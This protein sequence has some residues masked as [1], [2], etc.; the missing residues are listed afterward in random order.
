MKALT[1]VEI[2]ID[3]CELRYG[4][5]PCSAVLGEDSEQ[6]C[7]NTAATCPVRQDYA[8]RTLT[9]RYGMDTGFNPPE[10]H[11]LAALKSVQ[12]TPS[13]VRPGVDLGERATLQ[14][15]FR[16]FRTTDALL[17]PYVTERDYDPYEMGTYWGKFRA[18]N[19]YLVNSRLR[20][21]RGFVGQALEEMETRHFV[22]ESFGGPSAQGEFTIKAHDVLKRLDSDRAQAPLIS[23]GEL[24][25]GI[26]ATQTTAYL[27][28]TGIGDLEYPAAGKLNIGGNEI[29]DFTRS[30]DILTIVRGRNNT[31]EQ[32]HDEGDLVQLCLVYEAERP[33]AII[34]DLLVNYASI[35]PTF[36]PYADWETEVQFY[37]GRLYGAVIANPTPVK[38]LINELIEQIGLTMWTDEVA[39]QIRLQ[40]LRPV[41]SSAAQYNDDVILENSLSVTDQPDRRVSQVWTYFAM[42][43]PLEDLD[44][45]NNYK[46]A[47]ATADPMAS[48]DYEVPAYKIIYSRWI[49]QFNRPA[50]SR[51]NTLLLSRYRDAPRKVQFSLMS[52][53]S[54]KPRLGRGYRVKGGALQ[55]P[56]GEEFYMPIQLTSVN[57]RG[58]TI[59]VQAEEL[60]FVEIDDPSDPGGVGRAIIIDADTLDFNLRAEY[61][62]IY[63]PPEEGGEL[64]VIVESGVRVGSSSF[65]SAESFRLGDWPSGFQI[66]LINNGYIVGRGGSGGPG[67]FSGDGSPGA[68]ALYTRHPLTIKNYGIIGGGGGGGGGGV[69]SGQNAIWGGGGGGAGHLPGSSGPSANVSPSTQAGLLEGGK[70]G[71]GHDIYGGNGGG[72]G[73]PGGQGKSINV[74]GVVSYRPGGAAGAAVDGESFITWEELGDVRGPRIN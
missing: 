67:L 58:D 8:P 40:A 62:R 60:K 61:D 45:P 5:A 24:A 66:T 54:T 39:Q 37:I 32:E 73:Q 31:E 48:L 14:L 6:K 7:F 16:D 50:A 27:S 38:E 13:V 33:E 1:Y 49:G 20:L 57:D 42:V 63:T 19:P 52:T 59:S 9:L 10:I 55:L 25:V 35:D 22:I 15:K 26:N 69:R 44:D 72:L 56:T 17:D 28:P 36:I 43:N 64:T 74:F 4:V 53:V 71:A 68:T 3:F 65:S 51:L 30:G 11:C 23:R 47:V 21:I 12:Y 29:V 41:D 34:R 70:G 2:D 46:S 18:R